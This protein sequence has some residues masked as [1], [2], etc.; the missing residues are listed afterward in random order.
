MPRTDKTLDRMRRTRATGE[1]EAWRRAAAYG[2][3]VR[4]SGGS[5]VV[6]GHPAVAE[7]ISVSGAS[8]FIPP[9]L[10]RSSRPCE[11]AMSDIEYRFTVRP[12]TEEEGGGWLVEYPDLPGSM[13]DG[14]TIEEAIANAEDAKRCWIAAMKEAG[15]PIPPP[16]VEPAEGYSGKWQ[17]RVP[18]S[19]H[20]RLAEK[21][22]A[23]TPSPLRCWASARLMA[24]EQPTPYRLDDEQR[25]LVADRLRKEG[26]S[27]TRDRRER[28][29][30][31]IEASIARFRAT[32]PEGTFRDAH[33]ALRQLWELSHEDDPAIGQLRA[34]LTSLPSQAIEQLGRRARAVIPR[35]F[36][37]EMIGDEPFDPPE[38]LGARFL[39]WAANADGEKL[40]MALQ[41]MTAEGDQIVQGRSRGGSKRSG[42]RLEP[43]IM[44][45]VR[46]AGSAR[47][48]GGRPT[49]ERRQT[50][51]MHLA[52][53]W[54][55]A[56]RELPKPG[57]SDNTGFGDLVHSVFEW[58][59]QP[60]GSA[61]YA[62]R[63]YWAIARA[64]KARE[65]LADFLRRHG[66]E[67]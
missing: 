28:F 10:S 17:L 20:R 47:H 14:E 44:G 39:K 57:R 52:I 38:W 8:R 55:H 3:N 33:D 51:V 46:G 42:F 12:L 21:G 37:G 45:E 29:D 24:A 1:S 4:N 62:L 58:L 11:R 22:S 9:F 49:N 15:R 53:D 16:S 35:L 48:H 31:G 67:A 2:V 32:S 5:H 63:R 26:W 40:V 30:V 6:F 13:S 66:I 43:V 27:L 56:T 54:L 18:K 50:L 60:E 65:P 64:S 59:G 36:A 7:A 23:S 34:R 61:A 25:A 41:A 19:L